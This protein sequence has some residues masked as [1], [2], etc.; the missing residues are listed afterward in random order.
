MKHKKVKD[1]SRY[2]E[3]LVC[4]TCDETKVHP[5]VRALNYLTKTYTVDF[6]CGNGHEWT[7]TEQFV[8]L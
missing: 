4:P 8:K 7:E 3:Q 2:L 1:E 6:K 5:G